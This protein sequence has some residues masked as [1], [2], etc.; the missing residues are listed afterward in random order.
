MSELMATH[1]T[2]NIREVE[3]SEIIDIRER[4]AALAMQ[5][6]VLLGTEKFE[7]ANTR[8]IDFANQ[9]DVAPT[10]TYED[11]VF[12]NPLESTPYVLSEDPATAGHEVLFYRTH[13]EIENNLAVTITCLQSGDFETAHQQGQA[14]SDNFVGLYR[15]LDPEAFAAFRPYFRGLN[16]YPGPSGLFTAAIP[17]IDL[18][19]HGGQNMPSEERARLLRDTRQGLYPSHQTELLASLL[20]SEQ[21]RLDMPDTDRSA[22]V[23]LLNKFRKIHTGSVRKFVPEALTAGAEGS[24]GVA[25]VAGYLAS[26]LIS[27]AGGRND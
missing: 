19:I 7:A 18:L 3:P 15:K 17:I 8:L 16:N 26:K 10:M 5:A 25:D 12:A 14:A 21:P 9:L 2:I 27:I 6:T 22:I 1:Q 11:V 13:R 23:G 20:L 4:K 24:G